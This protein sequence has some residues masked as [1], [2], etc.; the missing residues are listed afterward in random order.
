MDFTTA[1]R[2]L[3]ATAHPAMAWVAT[4]EAKGL[5]DG[6][7]DDK[8]S[9]E[10]LLGGLVGDQVSLDPNTRRILANRSR[11][12]VDA[13]ILPG[14]HSQYVESVEQCM[15]FALRYF[16][17]SRAK[18][19]LPGTSF[20]ADFGEP[21]NLADET[22]QLASGA[23]TRPGYDAYLNGGITPPRAGDIL[24]LESARATM[25]HVAIVAGVERRG[26]RWVVQVYQANVPYNVNSPRFS[27]HLED[28]PMT[29]TRGKWTMAPYR[30]GWD[31]PK[32]HT[33]YW[34]NILVVGWIH[35]KGEKALPGAA[36]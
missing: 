9:T 5:V 33:S 15:E 24:V 3:A 1:K 14:D 35:P 16:K 36:K 27:D 26:D 29:Y 8:V 18:A 23:A 11:L 13:T 17:E 21:H 19:G 7:G 32:L 22:R 2:L 10:E 25:Y 4:P 28:L 31:L 30:Y 12:P 20:D 34:E 6:N